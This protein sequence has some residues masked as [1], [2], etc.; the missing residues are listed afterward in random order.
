MGDAFG[1]KTDGY[2]GWQ[3]TIHCNTKR[4]NICMPRLSIARQKSAIIKS[5]LNWYEKNA[6]P[7]PWR[8]THRPYRILV[9][10]I[11][12][13]Q[14]QVSR[15]LQKYSEF[16][17]RFPTFQSL[18]H[19]HP[20]DV[21]RAWDGMG[22][23]NRALHLHQTAVRVTEEFNGRM[24]KD[25]DALQHLPGIGRYTANAI[26]CFAFQQ[27]TA[28]VDTNVRRVL[29]RL[30]PRQAKSMDEW[31][32][33]T[34]ILPNDQAYEWNQA[35]M[36]LGGMVCTS[37]NPQCSVCPLQRF[38]GSAFTVKRPKKFT[39]K[40]RQKVLPDRIYR[41]RIISVLRTLTHHQS[42]ETHRLAIMVKTEFQ[43]SEKK[44]F[45][46]LLNGLR[47]DG[48]IH[49]RRRQKKFMVSLPR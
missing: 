30:F 45:E 1:I 27:Q 13:Q 33:A 24:P 42:I 10:E 16:L 17:R 35:L 37:S 41:G 47:R 43:S 15:V 40:K 14:T 23:N 29:S 7:M 49:I 25:I 5:L 21:I 46:S 12:L 9:S 31:S 4:L 38:C 19:A 18:A 44:W 26:F 48:L 6:R 8:K 22:Y 11:M 20:A 3:Q 34:W 28:V 39:S 32:L 2:T 36:E